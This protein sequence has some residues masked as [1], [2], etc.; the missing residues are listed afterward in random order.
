MNKQV[1]LIHG[2]NTFDSYKE[3]IASLKAVEFDFAKLRAKGW[4]EAL[5]DRLG[6]RFKVIAPR[7]PNSMNARYLEWKI[8]LEKLIPYFDKKVIL[9]GHSLGG[10]FLAK[11]L[12]EKRFPRKIRGIFLVAPPFDDRKSGESLADFKLPRDM[13]RAARHSDKLHL[14]FSTDDQ[15]VPF[16]NLDMYKKAFPLAKAHVFK[17]RGHFTGEKFPEIVRDIRKLY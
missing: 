13:K 3:Y 15:V 10:I 16:S 7:M 4:K 17:D 12:S 14:Y 2:G 5:E 9:V 1:I 11:Y 6:R 8:W